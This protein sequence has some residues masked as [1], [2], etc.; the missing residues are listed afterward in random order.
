VAWNKGCIFA[1]DKPTAKHC[2]TTNTGKRY[3]GSPRRKESGVIGKGYYGC[4]TKCRMF[5]PKSGLPARYVMNEAVA[6]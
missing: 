3:A 4:S 2:K 1:P 6:K 5:K